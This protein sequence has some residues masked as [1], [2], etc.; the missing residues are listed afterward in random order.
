MLLTAINLLICRFTSL[1][2]NNKVWLIINEL[3]ILGVAHNQPLLH[4]YRTIGA[5]HVATQSSCW[6]TALVSPIASATVVN[7]GQVQSVS[8]EWSY[9]FSPDAIM[10][11]CR[12]VARQ[13]KWVEAQRSACQLLY[14]K[15]TG[16]Q[17]YTGF[18]CISDITIS[19]TYVSLLLP[20][21]WSTLQDWCCLREGLQH[22]LV[23]AASE[24]S[25]WCHWKKPQ[26]GFVLIYLQK[27]FFVWVLIGT[28]LYTLRKKHLMWM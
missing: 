22:F 8:S 28:G 3:L 5:A 21:F 25:R 23:S 27:Y 16:L 7:A 10:S 2:I 15:T 19:S 11:H 6:T 17:F 13:S 9:L 4:K 14:V 20:L 18:V 12:R 1:L 24:M 26:S